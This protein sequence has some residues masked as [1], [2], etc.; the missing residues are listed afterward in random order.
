MQPF[1]RGAAGSSAAVLTARE[2]TDTACAR[3]TTVERLHQSLA[4]DLDNILLRALDKEASR[5]Y[6]S[7]E[8][9]SEDLRRYL[10][11][12]P[13]SARPDTLLYRSGKF[14]RRHPAGIAAAAVLAITLAAGIGATLWQARV[15]RVERARA[16]RRF[17]DV[18]TLA[19]SFL[20]EFDDSIKNLEGMT[21]SRELIVKR[22]LQYL[23]SLTAEAGGDFALQRE[24]AGAYD[25]VSDVQGNFR[26]AN[27]GDPK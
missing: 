3:S 11:G 14:V 15:A 4:G 20:F 26:T 8:H 21:A 27:L 1:H 12:L 16:E 10:G 13:V 9:F 17:N 6:S 7:V 25:K 19:N 22:A 5:R 24:I 2:N 18:R 23:N